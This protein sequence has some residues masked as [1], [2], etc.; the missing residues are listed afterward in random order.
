M[1]DA[2]RGEIQEMRTQIS[3]LQSENHRLRTSLSIKDKPS[4]EQEPNE[5]GMQQ[6]RLHP[7]RCLKMPF[8]GH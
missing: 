4:A 3:H 2:W 7:L 6:I 5:D 8:I 1:E